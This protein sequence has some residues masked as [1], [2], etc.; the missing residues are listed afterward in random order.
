MHVRYVL[1]PSEIYRTS[2]EH[3]PNA[4]RVTIEHPSNIHLTSIE[5]LSNIYPELRAVPGLNLK[6]DEFFA[7]RFWCIS[8]C[9]PHPTAPFFSPGP[10]PTGTIFL[11]FFHLF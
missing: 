4:H 11:P 1:H 10:L 5:Y 2:I 6:Y 3:L 7:K 8:Q 9:E